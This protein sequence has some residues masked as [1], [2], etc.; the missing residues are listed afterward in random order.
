MIATADRVPISL[1]DLYN[2]KRPEDSFPRAIVN[3]TPLDDSIPFPS[4]RAAMT[5]ALESSPVQAGDEVLLP[6]YTCRAVVEAVN[7]VAQPLFVDI[8]PRTYNIDIDAAEAVVTDDTQAIVPV[9]MYGKPVDTSTVRSFADNHDLVI[10]EDAAQALGATFTGNSVGSL[11]DYCVY[12]FRFTKEITSFK[13]GLLLTNEKEAI[14]EAAGN[15]GTPGRFQSGKLGAAVVVDGILE[16]L[17]GPLYRAL[18]EYVLDPLFQSSAGKASESYPQEFSER[19]H[20]LLIQ[21]LRQIRER[22]A[23][24]RYLAKEYHERLPKSLDKPT[25]DGEHTYFRYPVQV[26]AERRDALCST[27]QRRGIGCSKMYSYTLSSNGDCPNAERV[28]ERVIC[29]PIHSEMSVN[30]IIDI[31]ETFCEEWQASERVAYC[32]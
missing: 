30:Q 28:A 9:H 11:G 8:N 3:R 20:S 5:F 7:K 15:V 29:L 32:G 31:A 12:S 24:R 18:R 19:Q 10:L 22:V 2:A 13:G 25:L 21:Q 23:I 27:L 26:P 1:R 6:A 4:A 14:N 16:S 17:P